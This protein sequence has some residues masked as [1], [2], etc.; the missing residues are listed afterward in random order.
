MK[1]WNQSYEKNF[2]NPLTVAT[3]RRENYEEKITRNYLIENLIEEFHFVFVQINITSKAVSKALEWPT[4][5][6]GG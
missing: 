4:N 2:S 5:Y 1:T 6:Q 3:F